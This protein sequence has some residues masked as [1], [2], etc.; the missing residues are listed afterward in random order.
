LT[1]SFITE[2]NG[3]NK[4]HIQTLF[5]VRMKYRK[6]ITKPRMTAEETTRLLVPEEANKRPPP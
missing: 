1:K 2:I 3:F 6:T 5:K 4:M